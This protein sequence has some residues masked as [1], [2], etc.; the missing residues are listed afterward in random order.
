MDKQ[1]AVYMITNKR[2]GAVYIGVTSD[3]ARRITQHKEKQVD[4]F[5]K[6]HDA[7]VLVWYEFHETMLSAIE[8]EKQLKHW[9]RDWKITLIEKSNPYWNDLSETL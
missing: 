4:G 6:E 7:T 9:N 8:R 3:L 5:S 1:P 2:N